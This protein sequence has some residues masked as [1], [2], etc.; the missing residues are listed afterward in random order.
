MPVSTLFIIYMNFVV[1]PIGFYWEEC[2]KKVIGKE[3]FPSGNL[4]LLLQKLLISVFKIEFSLRN[5]ISSS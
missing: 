1:A 2:V 4:Y 3:I 5:G